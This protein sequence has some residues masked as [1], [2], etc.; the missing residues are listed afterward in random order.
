M[1]FIR[2]IISEKRSIRPPIAP[3]AA[4]VG[5]EDR[6]VERLEETR[7]DVREPLP[8]AFN[9][10]DQQAAEDLS[11]FPEVDEDEAADDPFLSNGADPYRDDLNPFAADLPDAVAVA[12]DDQPE[13]LDEA[14]ERQS[15]EGTLLL[16]AQALR[17]LKPGSPFERLKAQEAERKEAETRREAEPL[18]RVLTG[19]E[20]AVPARAPAFAMPAP[21]PEAVHR[22]ADTA[23]RPAMPVAE[24][25]PRPAVAMPA[26]EPAPRQAMP[27][28]EPAPRPAM[29]AMPSGE[30]APLPGL[31]DMPFVTARPAPDLNL[32]DAGLQVPPPA[33]GRGSNRSGRVKTRLLGFNPESLGVAS[34]FEKDESRVNDTFPVGWLVV[35]A[36]P[37][38]GASFSLHDGVS[39]IGRGEDQTVSLNFGDSAISR[40]NHVAV[41]FDSEANGFFI[42]QSGKSNIVRL[43]NKPLL[44]T[45]QLKSGDQI[46]VGETTLCGD[47]FSWAAVG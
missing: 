36:G 6:F 38:R 45:E 14:D 24:P 19:E 39:R 2:D 42:G 29:A 23:P 35:V 22:P 1:R 3:M 17:G 11:L 13:E 4:E 28:A 8:R 26:P 47:G 33:A 30:P 44:S 21:R 7:S 41:A 31:G 15:A 34:P 40:E 32:T 46:R 37:G 43:N 18:R 27:A 20:A 10:F 9:L 12:D 16:D 25:A 5:Q